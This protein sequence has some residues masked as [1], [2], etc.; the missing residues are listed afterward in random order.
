MPESTKLALRKL[1][2]AG[3]FLC[4]ATG[5]AQAMAVGYM[6]ELG[7]ENMVSDGGYG[8]TI[9]N[10]LLGITSLDRQKVINLIREC[11]QKNIVWALQTENSD[12]RFA[13]DKYKTCQR[14][15][16]PSARGGVESWS[17]ELSKS[18]MSKGEGCRS[19]TM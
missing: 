13:P 10:K 9:D 17:I 2:E 12:T 19:K 5:R 18:N 1:R 4:I 7:F 3:H 15:G 14:G 6:R 16:L 8:I 11:E